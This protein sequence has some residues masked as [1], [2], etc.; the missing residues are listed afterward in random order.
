MA[1]LRNAARQRFGAD[2][3]QIRRL[4]TDL[5]AMPLPGEWLEASTVVFPLMRI[6]QPCW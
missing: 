2:A 6:S 3:R 4:P 5:R 1:Q